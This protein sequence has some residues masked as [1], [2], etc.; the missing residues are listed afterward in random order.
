MC[1]VG[2]AETSR[3]AEVFFGGLSAKP[4]RLSA[5]LEAKSV[6]RMQYVCAKARGVVSEEEVGAVIDSYIEA[7]SA[8][9][10]AVSAWRVH[11][12][13]FARCLSFCLV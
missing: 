12:D 13:A 6:M 8:D 1:A 11:R 7:R 10:P 9:P 5:L 2:V 3:S 4:T